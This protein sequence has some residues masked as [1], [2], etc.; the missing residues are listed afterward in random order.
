MAAVYIDRVVQASAVVAVPSAP[1]RV[2]LVGFNIGPHEDLYF[3]SALRELDYTK[4]S[5]GFATFPKAVP[6]SPQYYRVQCS[7]NGRLDFDISIRDER[8]NIHF[9][10]PVGDELLLA[11]SRSCR[12]SAEDFDLNGRVYG[13]DGIFR[14]EFLLGDGIE[15]IQSTADGQIWTSY[16]DEG[17]FGNFGW[18]DPVGASGLIAWNMDG[19]KLYEFEP[20]PGFGSMA[21]CY[22]LNLAAD[23]DA[24]CYYYTDFAL[25]RI[26]NRKVTSAWR[27]PVQGS[28]AFA[29]ADGHAVFAGDY[30]DHDCL[31]LVR[32]Y[33]EAVAKL[34]ATFQLIDDRGEALHVERVIGRG[35]RLYILSGE[36][37]H[38]IDANDVV[39]RR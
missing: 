20:P 28:H 7:R 35:S 26:Q 19:E 27:S 6:K 13:R 5:P 8:F 4:E 33:S 21:D 10:Q 36:G 31:H 15:T 32:L 22:A 23:D 1:G 25:V 18:R 11:C 34:V 30:Q 9:A 29:I 17:V 14:R 16:F 2:A 38:V 12:R 3:V 37:V 39:A 24:W